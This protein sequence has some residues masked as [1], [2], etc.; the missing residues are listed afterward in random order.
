MI[1]LKGGKN[2]FFSR[3]QQ[4]RPETPE[5]DFGHDLRIFS[6]ARNFAIN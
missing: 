1:E 2:A 4:E 3:I 5:N 6:G